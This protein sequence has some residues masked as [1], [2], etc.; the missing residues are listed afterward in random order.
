MIGNNL[1]LCYLSS[2]SSGLLSIIP[3]LEHLLAVAWRGGMMP[4][5]VLF[6]AVNSKNVL[7]GLPLNEEHQESVLQGKIKVTLSENVV[8]DD[9][10]FIIDIGFY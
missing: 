9:M 1:F 7:R 2:A 8:G 10:T 5:A 6:S 3:F 4:Q